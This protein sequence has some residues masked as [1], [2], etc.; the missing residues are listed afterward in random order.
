MIVEFKMPEI[1]HISRR[2][3]KGFIGNNPTIP[4]IEYIRKDCS[5]QWNDIATA[6]LN[7]DIVDI[8]LD[9][10]N[11]IPDCFFCPDLGE[12]CEAGTNN[13]VLN[14]FNPAS[15]IISHWMIPPPPPGAVGGSKTS[16]KSAGS[17]ADITGFSCLFPTS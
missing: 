15:N 16:D 1:L 17:L 7:G 12:W 9:G 10:K 14:P 4:T 11:R 3:Y 2:T 6:P 5:P 13:P 8:L